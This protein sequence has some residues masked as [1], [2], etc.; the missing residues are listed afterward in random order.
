MRAFIA[1]GRRDPVIDVE[2]GRR[3]RDLLQAGGL[4]VEYRESN[5]THQIDPFQVPLAADWLERVLTAEPIQLRCERAAPIAARRMSCRARRPQPS[6]N[7]GQRPGT[8]LS[9]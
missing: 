2:F 3:A 8:P 6:A 7:S 9:S 1:H 5:V 4:D